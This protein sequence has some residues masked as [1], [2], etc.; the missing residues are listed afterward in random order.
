MVVVVV[1]YGELK[2][3]LLAIGH[4]SLTP[5]AANLQIQGPRLTVLCPMWVTL[6]NLHPS[7]WRLF[8]P[9]RLRADQE[10]FGGVHYVVEQFRV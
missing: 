3:Y 6:F 10:V 8:G 7:P 4:P 5:R 9:L 1:N 2:Y